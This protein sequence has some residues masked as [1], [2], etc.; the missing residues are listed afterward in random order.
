MNKKEKIE[1]KEKI[2]EALDNKSDE[3][4]EQE[5][6]DLIRE[7]MTEKQFWNY[8]SNWKDGD[9]LC[10]EMEEWDIETKKMR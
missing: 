3:E 4:I 9:S 2:I 8:V 10:E 6:S 5:F 7:V 1:I